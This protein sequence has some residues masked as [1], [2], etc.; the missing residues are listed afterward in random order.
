MPK[1]YLLSLIYF[2]RAVAILVYI[3]LPL[4]AL[5]TLVTDPDRD[6]RTRPGLRSRN[7]RR[8]SANRRPTLPKVGSISIY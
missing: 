8:G 7:A 6:L 5:S 4:S 2:G 1:R 3:L